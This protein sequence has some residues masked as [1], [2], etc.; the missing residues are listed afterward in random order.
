MNEELNQFLKKFFDTSRLNRLPDKYNGDRI[1]SSPIIGVARGNDPI[2]QKYKEIIGSEHL[3]PIEVWLAEGYERVPS[4]NLRII[5]IVFP[6]SEKIRKESRNIK[7]LLEVTIPAEVYCIG[8]NY[9]NAF[10]KETCKQIIE[11]LK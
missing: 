5:S 6:F 2:S 1:F 4:S 3:T 10:K 8:R 7:K 9:A 11:F